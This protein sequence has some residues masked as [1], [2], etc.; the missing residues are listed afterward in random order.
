MRCGIRAMQ[1]AVEK[2]AVDPTDHEVVVE[3]VGDAPP[4]G[5]C[6]SGYIDAVAEMF[7]AGVIDRQGAIDA[8]LPTARTRQGDGA[9]EFVAWANET[10]TDADIVIAQSDIEN[11]LRSKGAIYA[12]AKLLVDAMGLTFDDV[13]NIY[14]GGGFGNYLDIE[15]AVW[16]GLLPDLPADR[17]RFIGN[18]SLTGAKAALLSAD[19]RERA[20][21]VADRM[22]NM[23]L[24]AEPAY[25][26]EYMGSLFIPHTDID[27]FPTVKQGMSA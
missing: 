25:M 5:I 7:R 13:A 15:A 24:C 18:S 20:R 1:G 8:S 16:I 3:T 27:L 23:E 21:D 12:A 11:L 19:A 2:V 17:F 14:I 9:P 4:I 10:G 22:T 6:G 26:D